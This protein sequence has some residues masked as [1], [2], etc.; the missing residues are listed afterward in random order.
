MLEPHERRNGCGTCASRVTFFVP[1]QRGAPITVRSSIRE[2]HVGQRLN[3]HPT[4]LKP[5]RK[6]LLPAG[7]LFM[8]NSV[9]RP[10]PHDKGISDPAMLSDSYSSMCP[11]HALQ[12]CRTGSESPCICLFQHHFRMAN[13]ILI[14]LGTYVPYYMI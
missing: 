7:S 13:P 14:K 10:L 2:V 8:R 12:V 4:A 6:C 11:L 3:T 1:V 9:Q 5:V